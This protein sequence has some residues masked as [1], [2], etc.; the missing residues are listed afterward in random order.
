[1]F[2]KSAGG[3]GGW[4]GKVLDGRRAG[5][6]RS[7]LRAWIL[8]GGLGAENVRCTRRACADG[9]MRWQHHESEASMRWAACGEGQGAGCI[10]ARFT[11]LVELEKWVVP[12]ILPLRNGCL[13]EKR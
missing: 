11:N 7:P 2:I 8:L 6:A 5:R 12:G 1:M 3:R 9:Q 4:V 13:M 10:R